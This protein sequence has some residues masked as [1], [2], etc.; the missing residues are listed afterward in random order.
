MRRTWIGHPLTLLA[1]VVLVVN[2]HVLKAAWPGLVTGKLSDVAGL[3]VL[4]PLLDLALRRPMA[5]I[6]VTGLGFTLVKTTAT[7]AWLASEAWTIVWGPSRVL[8]DPT[9]LL[10]LP[11]LGAAWWA[12]RRRAPVREAVVL[13]IVPLAMLGLA[14]SSTLP[15]R[16]GVAYATES[17][18][19]RV[20]V[21]T[22][23]PGAAPYLAARHTTDGR[24]WIYDPEAGLGT[25]AASACVRER[26]HR[27]VPGRLKVEQ[28]TGG[29]WTTAWEVPEETRDRV[30]RAHDPSGRATVE[31]VSVA[32][33]DT[34]VVVANGADGV[35]VRDET[36]T[37]RR[38]PMEA[39]GGWHPAVSLTTSGRHDTFDYALT[40]GVLAA[41]LVVVAGSRRA[42]VGVGAVLVAVGW[43]LAAWARDALLVALSLGGLFAVPGALILCLAYDPRRILWKVPLRGLAFGVLAYS[44]TT[45]VFAAWNAGLL[46]YYADAVRLATVLFVVIL[47][48]GAVVAHRRTYDPVPK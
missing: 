29:G 40:A 37:W 13:T 23:V 47:V 2:D 8:A 35:V 33:T 20:T 48:V 7:G 9:D 27:I 1:L 36:G 45:T 44:S 31:S 11:A 6:A 3:L 39:L 42:W 30:S 24:R 32:A 22:E 28:S 10:A 19:D 18:G 17:D 16:L 38:V 46:T 41:L 5:S 4:P 25:A 34:L 15:E 14:A 12:S 21:F 43:V 26:C